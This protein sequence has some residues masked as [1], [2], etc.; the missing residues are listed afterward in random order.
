MGV[1]NGYFSDRI[2]L[3]IMWKITPVVFGVLDCTF[4]FAFLTL[5]NRWRKDSSAT[6]QVGKWLGGWPENLVFLTG[7]GIRYSTNPLF[8]KAYIHKW[9]FQVI[10]DYEKKDENS[11]N[12]LEVRGRL[13]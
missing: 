12:Y 1:K 11:V 5:K 9:V 2:S 13:F 4:C 7:E 3:Y 8:S 6:D 10:I